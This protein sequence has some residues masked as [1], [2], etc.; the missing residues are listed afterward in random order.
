MHPREVGWIEVIVGSMFS[1]KTEELLRRIRR[2][3]IARQPT[4]L[5]KPKIDTRYAK[6]H[7]VSHDQIRLPSISVES[8]EEI[9]KLAEDAMVVGVDEAQFF[10]PSIVEVCNELANQG[11]RVIVAG[12]DQDYRGIPFEPMP[13]LMASAEYITKHLAICSQCGNPAHYN[14]RLVKEAGQVL[15]GSKDLYEARCRRCFNGHES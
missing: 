4:I 11:K 6:D 9:L 2:A 3:M 8:P 10:H 15:L 7:V 13:A 14:Q 1:G 5:V 12:L